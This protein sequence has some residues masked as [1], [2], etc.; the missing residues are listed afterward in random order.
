MNGPVSPFSDYYSVK[1]GPFILSKRLVIIENDISA[2]FSKTFEKNRIINF[3][4]AALRITISKCVINRV[5]NCKRTWSFKN[6]LYG[7]CL[8]LDT[9][10]LMDAHIF[11]DSDSKVR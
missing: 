4:S 11:K 7:N 1:Q 10:G 9:M 5:K 3:K 2:F 6:S 8:T